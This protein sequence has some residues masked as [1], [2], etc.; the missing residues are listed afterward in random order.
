MSVLLRTGTVRDAPI[1]FDIYKD[2]VHNGT[3]PH[4]TAE[5]SAAWAPLD[6]AAD[7]IFERFENGT[8]WI[9]ERD[10]QPLGFLT[11]T[12]EG[13]LDLFFLRPAERRT[14][15]SSMLYDAYLAHF[16]DTPRLTT[17]ASHLA[18][19]FLERRGWHVVAEE[20][21]ERNGVPLTRFRMILDRAA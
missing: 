21:H 10:G 13:H 2:A 6:G 18:R 14:G 5:E 3:A 19:R 4:Y 7:W 1:C 9:A 15:I 16:P 17:F 20:R 11:A 8:T 12:H